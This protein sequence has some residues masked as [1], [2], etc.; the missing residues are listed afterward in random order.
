V[1]HTAP[2]QQKNPAISESERS[3]AGRK[4]GGVRR[5]EDRGKVR[6]ER[7]EDVALGCKSRDHVTPGEKTT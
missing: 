6:R 2:L 1:D 4:G 7:E 3:N 5:V